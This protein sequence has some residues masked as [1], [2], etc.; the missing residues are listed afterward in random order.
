MSRDA[1]SCCE[2]VLASSFRWPRVARWYPLLALVLLAWSGNTPA[3][4]DDSGSIDADVLLRDVAWDQQ[5]QR[6]VFGGMQIVKHPEFAWDTTATKPFGA[7]V[8]SGL[9]VVGSFTLPIVSKKVW[10]AL[11]KVHV[12]EKGLVGYGGNVFYA[13]D[14]SGNERLLLDGTAK[15]I[16]FRQIVPDGNVHVAL[17][18]TKDEKFNFD[19]RDVFNSEVKSLGNYGAMNPGAASVVISTPDRKGVTSLMWYRTDGGDLGAWEISDIR[20][21]DKASIEK[22]H[23]V[24]NRQIIAGTELDLAYTR[25]AALTRNARGQYVLIGVSSDDETKYKCDPMSNCHDA[26]YL[27]WR[28]VADGTPKG[29]TTILARGRQ[30]SKSN[31]IQIK[32]LENNRFLIAESGLDAPS[33]M[34]ARYPKVDFF[35]VDAEGSVMAKGALDLSRVT[36]PQASGYATLHFRTLSWVVKPGN[37]VEAFVGFRGYSEDKDPVTGEYRMASDKMSRT[38]TFYGK[39]LFTRVALN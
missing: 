32:L 8:D 19:K 2:A 15:R 38:S 9:K 18:T 3:S 29:R 1:S 5:S 17:F 31:D 37:R 20:F 23:E 24:P 39:F 12:S 28:H 36:H 27:V 25:T 33:R 16:T 6:Y 14:R 13:F 35:L 30:V 10:S 4:A 21:G 26:A 22:R 34:V 7:F 11:H